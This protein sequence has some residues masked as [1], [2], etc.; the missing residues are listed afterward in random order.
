MF[1]YE[2]YNRTLSCVQT[3]TTV[4]LSALYKTVQERPLNQAFGNINCKTWLSDGIV[5]R[6]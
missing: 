3:L 5:I 2:S 6:Y 4:V 1:V